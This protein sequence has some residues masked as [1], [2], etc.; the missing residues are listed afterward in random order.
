[1][2]EAGITTSGFFKRA[3]DRH[4]KLLGLLTALKK[5]AFP[6]LT[7]FN[8][9]PPTTFSPQDQEKHTSLLTAEQSEVL[10]K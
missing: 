9:S 7:Q 3:H 10:A 2:T 8:T 6:R 5:S 1:M 4:A